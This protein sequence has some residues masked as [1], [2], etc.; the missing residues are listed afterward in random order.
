MIELIARTAIDPKGWH[1]VIARMAELLPGTKIMLAAGDAQS[2]GN[3]GSIYAGFSDW[4]MQA[5]ADHF[6]K[7][8]PWTPYLM[9]LP[10][11][12]AAVSDA[13]MP[14]ASF[15]NTEFYQDWLMR[16]GEID[17]AAG[18]KIF[19]ER[20]RQAAVFLHYGDRIAERYNAEIKPLLQQLA[21]LFRMALEV[22]RQLSQTLPYSGMIADLIE[23]FRAPVCLVN[24]QRK[25]LLANKAF[26]EEIR[27]RQYIAG[28]RFDR[29]KPANTCDERKFEDMVRG[30]TRP[31]DTSRAAQPLT[32]F[33][34]GAERPPASLTVL[35]IRAGAGSGFPRL[36]NPRSYALVILG[37]PAARKPSI[38][39]DLAARFALTRAEIRLLHIVGAGENLRNAADQLG[40]SYET[41]RSQLKVIFS[42]TDVH[43]QAELVALMTRLAR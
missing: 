38:S 11:M 37:N 9:Q 16:E 25:M 35:G 2:I 27:S 34:S 24:E 41:A 18:V 40:I 13:V 17:H 7:V 3:V 36:A 10:T 12:L 1:D 5:Y 22:N 8:N 14:A 20:D 29:I 31:H 30:A 39:R 6:S 33:L 32:M 23:G 26:L 15:G 4:S 19:H 21:P 28:D 43:R 42:K